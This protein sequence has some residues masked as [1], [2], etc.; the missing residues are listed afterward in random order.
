MTFHGRQALIP[1]LVA[2]TLSGCLKPADGPTEQSTVTDTSASEPAGPPELAMNV[3]VQKGTRDDYETESSQNFPNPT[4]AQIEEQVR[5]LDWTS[6]EGW[7]YVALARM[8]PGSFE[9]LSVEGT[10]GSSDPEQTLRARW[11]GA[12]GEK[13]FDR[14]SPPL[15]S[16]DEAVKLLLAFHGKSAEL[17][18]QTGWEAPVSAE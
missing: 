2:F 4:A 10:L 1:L 11:G 15:T 3:T 13:E 6:T 16:L 5:R 9:R 8:K 17:S 18:T 14:R 12:E 7:C